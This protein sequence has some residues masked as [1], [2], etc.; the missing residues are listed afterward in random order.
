MKGSCNHDVECHIPELN[1][2]HTLQRDT[3]ESHSSSKL[4]LRI[5]STDTGVVCI[6]VAS[7]A[8]TES[9]VVGTTQLHN[10]YDRMTAGRSSPST[11]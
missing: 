1:A 2:S 9:I 11:R 4:R 7:I 5:V 3:T 6:A 8:H 10:I